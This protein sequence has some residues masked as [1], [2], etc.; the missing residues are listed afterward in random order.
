MKKLSSRTSLI[1]VIAVFI[2]VLCSVFFIIIRNLRNTVKWFDDYETAKEYA[3]RVN[4]D[5]FLAFEGSSWDEKSSQ[6]R[7]DILDKKEFLPLV[8]SDFVPVMLSIPL[9]D[10]ETTFTE[11]E[12]KNIELSRIFAIPEIPTILVLTVQNQVYDSIPY[13]S[14]E[15]TLQTME[16]ALADSVKKSKIVKA[17]NEKLYAASGE[18]KV[19][20]I[21]ELVNV[22]PQD[23]V[24]QFYNLINTVPELDPTNKTGLVGKYILLL[25][26]VDALEKFFKG[27][28]AGA[29]KTYEEAALN[30]LL[31]GDE[32]LEAYYK[33]ATMCY[34]GE[35]NEELKDYLAKA[36]ASSPDSENAAIL[37]KTLDNFIA[38][39]KLLLSAEETTQE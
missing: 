29:A 35:L 22:T 18:E 2:L 8:G 33:A 19:K 10:G 32:K 38:D 20:I 5:I 1:L 16:F 17:L 7:T 37:Q 39:E 30:S 21:D 23:Y 15:S 6:L 31:T 36:I 34:Y 4:K 11:Q 12:T 13:T 28:V 3:L 27:D 26:H 14:G 25:T 9:D 24:F